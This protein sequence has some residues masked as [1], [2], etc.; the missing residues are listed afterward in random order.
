MTTSEV[1]LL[2]K[3]LHRVSDQVQRLS[4]QV[5][6]IEADLQGRVIAQEELAEFKRSMGRWIIGSTAALTSII[7]VSLALIDRI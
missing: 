4:D 1:T 5:S 7:T 6:N 2:Q 3:E